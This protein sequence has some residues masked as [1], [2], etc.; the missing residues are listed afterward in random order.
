MFQVE[1]AQKGEPDLPRVVLAVLAEP[2]EARDKRI[3]DALQREPPVW[4]AVDR[5]LDEGGQ[6]RKRLLPL[7]WVRD[8]PEVD[9]DAW[10]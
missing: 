6:R 7:W 5:E 4:A 1:R 9:G 2:R 10:G 3:A 8:G